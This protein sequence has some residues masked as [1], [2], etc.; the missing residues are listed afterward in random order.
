MLFIVPFFAVCFVIYFIFITL[1]TLTFLLL[2]LS[3]LFSVKKGQQ[4]GTFGHNFGVSDFHVQCPSCRQCLRDSACPVWTC[5]CL[6][7][8]IRPGRRVSSTTLSAVTVAGD[9][10]P[11]TSTLTGYGSSS[12]VSTSPAV[13]QPCLLPGTVTK[14]SLGQGVPPTSQT[15]SVRGQRGAQP[16]RFFF[17]C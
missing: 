12:L 4:K 8:L 3:K 9:W 7:G 1:W 11:V 16:G 14:V 5:M 2:F 6:V 10:P 13:S 15:L 17:L